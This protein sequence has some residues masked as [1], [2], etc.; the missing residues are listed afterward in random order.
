MGAVGEQRRLFRQRPSKW[1]PIPFGAAPFGQCWAGVQSLST[2]G[3]ADPASLRLD[4][5]GQ[6]KESFQPVR[7]R[8]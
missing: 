2:A 6:H 7:W 8:I 3:P 1:R 5:Y 4:T